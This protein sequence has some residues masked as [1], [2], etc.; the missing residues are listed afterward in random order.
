MKR[1]PTAQYVKTFLNV[2]LKWSSFDEFRR[3]STDV[4][5]VIINSLD[6]P[7]STCTCPI[8]LKRMSCKHV[9]G[10]K[11]RLQ[12]VEVPHAAMEVPLGQKRKRGRPKL[13][14]RALLRDLKKN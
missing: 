5:V 4:W 11:I 1:E 2:A 6:L 9:L 8:F 3:I 12:L 7:E 13:A 14:T 10:M